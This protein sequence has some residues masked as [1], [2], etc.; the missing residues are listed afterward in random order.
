M[1][2][3][4]DIVASDM[5]T[6]ASITKNNV[7]KTTIKDFKE[8]LLA[9][10]DIADRIATYD[11]GELPANTKLNETLFDEYFHKCMG[12]NTLMNVFASINNM[13]KPRSADLNHLLARDLV[14]KC[15]TNYSE[16]MN[17]TIAGVAFRYMEQNK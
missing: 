16:L 2:T 14:I 5:A 10:A 12:Q 15:I 13:E 17:K 9:M 7:V 4:L 8:V 3:L 6:R 1:A 11:V